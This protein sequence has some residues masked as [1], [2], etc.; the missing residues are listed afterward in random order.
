M[1]GGW[2]HVP[3]VP[4][5]RRSTELV[6]PDVIIKVILVLRYVHVGYFSKYTSRAVVLCNYII[7]SWD[8]NFSTKG[9]F[10][11]MGTHPSSCLCEKSHRI[12]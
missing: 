1:R 7:M 8:V 11:I 2:V 9:V 6:M 4:Y 5:G 10:W 3:L 12:I